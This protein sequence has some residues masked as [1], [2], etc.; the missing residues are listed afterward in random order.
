[1]HLRGYTKK[2]IIQIIALL[3][4]IGVKKIAPCHCTGEYAMQLLQE[5]YKE[6][7]IDVAA[8]SV[9][10]LEPSSLDTHL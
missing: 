7:Y 4:D 1:L 6:D 10:Q 8:G 3:K 9:I 5:E 2:D